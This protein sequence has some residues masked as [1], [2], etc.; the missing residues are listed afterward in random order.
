MYLGPTCVS[1]LSYGFE[2]NCIRPADNICSPVASYNFFFYSKR[3]IRYRYFS[4]EKG[5]GVHFLCVFLHPCCLPLLSKMYGYFFSLLKTLLYCSACLN[6][7]FVV[8]FWPLGVFIFCFVFL[9][10]SSNILLPVVLFYDIA[11]H[12]CVC[13]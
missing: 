4:V 13:A 12:V 1:R 11:V 5:L 6:T 2:L 8:L 10:V 9:L 7:V 3:Y